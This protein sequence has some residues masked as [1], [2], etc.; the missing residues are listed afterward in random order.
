MIEFNGILIDEEILSFNLN[1]YSVLIPVGVVVLLILWGVWWW[2]DN[3]S[4]PEETAEIEKSRLLIRHL[5][6]FAENDPHIAKKLAEEQQRHKR[7][8]GNQRSNR[9]GRY[10]LLGFIVVFAVA[11]FFIEWLPTYQDIQH[12]DYVTYT[13][14]FQTEW[15]K[16]RGRYSLWAIL[17][18]DTYLELSKSAFDRAPQEDGTYTG[19]IVY[20]SRSKLV[21][22]LE[23]RTK[24]SP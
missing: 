2:M 16:V 12:K 19:T 23:W 8:T 15:H 17:P 14:T 5:E 21:L 4:D 6:K 10:L 18:D 22:G 1:F 13:G 7:L 11:C 24:A 9:I 3:K 20:S